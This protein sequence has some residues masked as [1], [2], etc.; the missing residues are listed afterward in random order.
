MMLRTVWQDIRYSLR[1]L[2]KT[3]GF[4]AVAVLTLALGIGANTAIFSVLDSVL[5]RSLP[6]AHPEQLAVLTDPD[7]HGTHFGSQTGERS[8]LAYSEFEYLRDHNEVFSEI[9]AADSSLPEVEVTIGDSVRHAGEGGETVRAR[10]VSG[11]YFS[12]L[13]VKPAAGPNVYSRGGSRERWFA[14]RRRELYVLETA[15]WLES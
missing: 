6:V 14:D 13:G 10:L 15:L 1:M 8:L 7:D 5:L 3:P 2:E 11:E 12:A 9:F 4:T